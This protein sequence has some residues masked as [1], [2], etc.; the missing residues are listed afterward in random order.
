MCGRFFTFTAT[1]SGTCARN[2]WYTYRCRGVDR[3]DALVHEAR[4]TARLSSGSTWYRSASAH[5]RV[6]HVGEPVGLLGGE[7]VALRRVGAHVVELPRR[8]LEAGLVGLHR[9]VRDRLPPVVVDARGSR[10]SRSTA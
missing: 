6:D 2:G 3:V 1:A 5:H 9:V 4:R 7:V 8:L 10:T